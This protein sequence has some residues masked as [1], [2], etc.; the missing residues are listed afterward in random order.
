M[1]HYVWDK[2]TTK[3]NA[4]YFVD[5]HFKMV[6]TY[7]GGILDNTD[8]D[9]LRIESPRFCELVNQRPC[10][11]MVTNNLLFFYSRMYKIVEFEQALIG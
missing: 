5:D 11:Q 2:I 6:D 4:S 9:M 8:F 1:V 10:P 3:Y 7:H